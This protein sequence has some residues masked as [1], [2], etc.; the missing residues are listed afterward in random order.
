MK[1]NDDYYVKEMNVQI[2]DFKMH[3]KLYGAKKGNST[4]I[5]DAGYGDY[6]KTWASIIPEISRLTQVLVYDRSGLG[7]SERSSYPRTSI[8]MVK[9]LKELLLK[10][11]ING[12]Y[13]LVGH[14]FG[15]VNARV[16]ASQYPHEL[17]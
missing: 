17:S 2:R 15:G 8:E 10:L 9:E 4:V 12:P 13:I 11:N 3:A 1:N 6:S 16:F 5:M 14:S 7:K